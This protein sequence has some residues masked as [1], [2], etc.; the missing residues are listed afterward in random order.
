MEFVKYIRQAGRAGVDIMLS[1]SYEWPRSTSSIPS[2]VYMRA[3]ENGF[4]FLRPT[5]HG[6]TFAVDYSGNILA[7]MRSDSDIMYAEV[8]TRGT[9]TLYTRV[10]DLLGWICLLGLAGLIVLHVARAIRRKMGGA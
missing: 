3:I 6:V 10:G 9:A 2:P 7:K 8:P 4:S 1:P 5:Y